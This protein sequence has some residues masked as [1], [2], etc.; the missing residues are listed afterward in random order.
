MRRRCVRLP[1][2]RSGFAGFRFPS[3]VILVA[4]RWYLRYGLS[5]RDVEE[6]LAERGIT[7]DHVTVYRWVQRFTPLLIDAA[8]PCRHAPGD[9]WFVDETYVKVAGRWVYLYRAIDQYGQV[10]D[11]LISPKR[12]LATTHRFF[13]RA[14]V[15]GRCP[16]EVTT[17]RA[18]AYPRVIEQLF[19]AAW[20]VTE[21]YANNSVEADHGRLKSRLR[22]MRGLK[23]LRSA[24]VISAGH[25]FIQN[26][27]RGHYELGTEEPV[28]LRVL[29]AFD[30]LALAI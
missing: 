11:V 6:L 22:P 16:T 14:L 7:V 15:H 20:H 30:E 9:R 19:P 18:A 27:Y 29:A 12:D 1:V 24:R 3:D 23:Q 13:M 4:V 5:Y 21:Q 8:R 2:P 28:N 25:A 10:I 26:L 17:D